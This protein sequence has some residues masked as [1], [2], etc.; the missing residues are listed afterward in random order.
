M[1]KPVKKITGNLNFDNTEIIKRF[2]KNQDL[3]Q[4]RKEFV[5]NNLNRKFEKIMKN[6]ADFK[7]KDMNEAMKMCQS[8]GIFSHTSKE[9]I[10][11]KNQLD[12]FMNKNNKDEYG[13]FKKLKDAGLAY[14]KHKMPDKDISEF[15][16]KNLIE[17]PDF[18]DEV[19]SASK[20]RVKYIICMLDACKELAC[21]YKAEIHNE[22][23]IHS[24]KMPDM[25]NKSEQ[26]DLK[27]LV[28]DEIGYKLDNKPKI[29]ENVKILENDEP[30]I[31]KHKK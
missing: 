5:V 13:D 1:K 28:N 4:E 21:E 16:M 25:Y 18:L 6:D 20:L 17:K 23:E 7:N 11:F 8:R 31:N 19:S 3:Y 30:V 9:F 22:K 10:S 12:S 15:T 27:H 14:L 26:L 2:G 29:R 24:E